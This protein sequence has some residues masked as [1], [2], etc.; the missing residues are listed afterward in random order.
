MNSILPD[1]LQ[2]NKL[3]AWWV[4]HSLTEEQEAARVVWC[5]IMLKKVD[6][7]NTV[8]GD[9]TCLYYYE[10]ETKRQ[11]TVVTMNSTD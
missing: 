8:T 2:V 10:P 11:S 9:E 1:Y 4:S 6:I 3:R 5:H 7:Y